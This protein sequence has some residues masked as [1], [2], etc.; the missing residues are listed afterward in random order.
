[1]VR[2]ST[3][4]SFLIMTILLCIV[5]EH[6]CAVQSAKSMNFIQNEL[7]AVGAAQQRIMSQLKDKNIRIGQIASPHDNTLPSH[8]DL[9]SR[10]AI[11]TR[12][13]EIECR[14]SLGKAPIGSK[15]VAPCGCKGSQKW[16][17][18]SEYN[19][20]RRKDPQ[21]WIT[22]QTC[23][24]P[25]QPQLFTPYG[26]L[27]GALVGLLLERMYIVR[28]AM[29]VALVAISYALDI[30]SFVKQALTSRLFWDWVSFVLLL[31][32]ICC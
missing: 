7:A 32:I 26:G 24:Q 8:S 15:C 20:L 30:S 6:Q 13:N 11:S 12:T 21:Q 19:K 14:I 31:I 29:L 16:I 4:R 5:N 28:V 9:Q 1:M 2:S 17:Q 25:F 10:T 18:F 23:Q 3:L 27:K 22:C